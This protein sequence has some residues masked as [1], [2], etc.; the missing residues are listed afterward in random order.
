[1][2]DEPVDEGEEEDRSASCMGHVRRVFAIS[3][4]HTDDASNFQWLKDVCYGGTLVEDMDLPGE[5]DALIVA[6]DIS[7]DMARLRETLQVLKE[8]LKC[9]VFFVSGNHEAWT[10]REP[11]LDGCSIA[12]LEAIDQ[13]CHE[14]GIVTNAKLLG[15]T[16]DFPVWVLPMNSWYD[17]SL[18]KF[19]STVD[20]TESQSRFYG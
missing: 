10:V 1:M 12:K 15:S 2:E 11:G 13:L 7:H 20:L 6:G 9:E 16:H 19:S 18:G 8:G 14:L 4:L 3:D 17:G 5:D